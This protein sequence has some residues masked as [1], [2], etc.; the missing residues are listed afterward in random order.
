M[1]SMITPAPCPTCQESPT[2]GVILV[3]AR[4]PD[5]QQL[6]LTVIPKYRQILVLLPGLSADERIQWQEKLIKDY[7]ACGC[8]TGAYFL[9]GGILFTL[10]FAALYWKA[11]LHSWGLSIAKGIAIWVLCALLGKMIGWTAAKIRLE[12]NIL[13]LRRQVL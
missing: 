4:I 8:T 12:V 1:N 9:I 3:V 2:K 6:S 10:T 11:I 5:L 13:R 7:T